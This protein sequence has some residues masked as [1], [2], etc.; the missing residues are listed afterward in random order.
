[1]LRSEIV[2]E[3]KRW[4]PFTAGIM[5][6]L[7]IVA[8]F[9]IAGRGLG[10]T[11][12]MTAILAV[13]QDWLLPELTA[14]SAYFAAYLSGPGHPL[15]NYLVYVLAGT[16][17]GA[18]VAAATGND[19]RVKVLRGPRIGAGERLLFALVGGTLVGFAA[20]LARGCTSGQ[21]LVGGAELSVGSWVFVLCVFA[22]GFGAAYFVR[23]QW[24]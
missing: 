12:G 4:S 1:M 13:I 22:G 3:C 24:L 7:T 5:L 16:L 8:T 11:G 21:A 19:L 10:A 17:I 2:D 9:Y 6:G 15:Q 18:F 20:R 23:R 14:K